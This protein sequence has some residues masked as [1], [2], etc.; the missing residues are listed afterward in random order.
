LLARPGA[1]P[2]IDRQ[3]SDAARPFEPNKEASF[4]RDIWNA[5]TPSER[6]AAIYRELRALD[7]QSVKEAKYAPLEQLTP[8]DGR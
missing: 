4:S 6:S 2:S 5:M 3:N 8:S 1:V 7:A